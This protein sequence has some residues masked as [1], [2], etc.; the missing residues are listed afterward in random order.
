MNDFEE[1]KTSM[2]EVTADVVEIAR[3][4]ELEVEP[5]DVPELVH[6][7]DRTWMAEELLVMDEQREWFL[8]ME[9]APGEDAVRIVEITTEDLEYYINLAD[10]AASGFQRI[11]SN[12]ERSSAVGKM[13]WT[14]CMPQRKRS[15]MEE[16]IHAA[17]LIAVVF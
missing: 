5:E 7:H 8:E 13:L 1:F 16:S 10:K 2:K 3:E 4:V 14:T 9:S 11:D 17:I 12:F 6:S 15:W